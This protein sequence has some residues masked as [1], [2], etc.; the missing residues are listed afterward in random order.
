MD[1]KDITP[2]IANL[3]D[4]LDNL[5]DALAPL[6]D[7][8]SGTANKLPLFDKARL[9]IWA[10]YAIENIMFS[11]LR[12]NGVDAREHKVFGELSRVR[13]Y[14]HK[15]ARL[16]EKD[17]QKD[18]R[19]QDQ[20]V[21]T[22]AAIRFLRSDLGD[23]KTVKTK[24]NQQLLKEKLKAARQQQEEQKKKQ[25]QHEQIQAQPEAQP[26]LLPLKRPASQIS[27]S[28]NE[29][30]EANSNSE[31]HSADS[32]SDSGSGS[33]AASSSEDQDV[34]EDESEPE[35][36]EEPQQPAKKARKNN[37]GSSR[38]QPPRIKSKPK[39]LPDTRPP[40]SQTKAKAKS[41]A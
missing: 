24:L 25:Q 2:L 40:K 33:D 14:F 4:D 18:E 11:S 22:Q 16:Q 21:D 17:K 34:Q 31:E 23:D 3:D 6:M 9:Y 19:P 36:S 41:K 13:Q 38:K 32:D 15:I 20:K 35:E 27:T 37:N 1:V 10:T 12:L 8:L 30:E 29:E 26:P 7:D 28:D 5:E 39:L